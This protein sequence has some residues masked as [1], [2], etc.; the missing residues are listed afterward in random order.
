M[1]RAAV[2]FQKQG[3]YLLG[4]DQAVALVY[5]ILSAGNREL[6]GK[7]HQSTQKFKPFTHAADESRNSFTLHFS[8]VIP[9]I[10]GAF[11]AGAKKLAECGLRT[12]HS[13]YKIIDSVCISDARHLPGRITVRTISPIVLSRCENGKKEYI[14][15]SRNADLWLEALERN[16]AKKVLAFRGENGQTEIR[17]VTRGKAALVNYQQTKIPARHITLE[18]KGGQEALET[19]IYGGLGERTGSGFGMVWPA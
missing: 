9:E 18:I 2:I 6:A 10:T 16:L 4:Y 11:V 1:R 15:Y 19:A 12:G 13:L 7:L 14:L 5:Q 8:S 17:P 3:N